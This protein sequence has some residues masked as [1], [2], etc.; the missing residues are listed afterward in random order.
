[1]KIFISWSGN[2]SKL[3]AEY[4]KKWIEQI[5]QAAEPWISVE[6]EKGKK[7]NSE[8]SNK[9]ENSKV[10]IFCVTKEN[11]NSPWIL[12]EAGAIAKTEDSFV[13]TF[14]I[15]L[16]PTDLTGPLSLFQ[17]TRFNK[18]DIFKLLITI[19]KS[20]LKSGG[21]SLTIENLKDLFEMFYPQLEENINL[22]IEKQK[23]DKAENGEIRSERELLEESVEILR[24]LKQSKLDNPIEKEAKDLLTYYAQKYAK[25][26]GTSS[27]YDVGTDEHF[28]DFMSKIH[29]NPL[30]L[31]VY[32][33]EVGL[34]NYVKNEFD[35]LPF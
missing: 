11:I 27:H 16:N 15:D 7:W 22:I 25:L 6:I 1:M 28:E 5:I 2:D 20:I 34:K 12:F 18:E 33:G 24:H 9:L 26:V 31:K 8:V 10:G 21:K 30:L 4:L 23:G 17:A 35:G 29:K 32:G 19:N 3:I 13:C 14:L